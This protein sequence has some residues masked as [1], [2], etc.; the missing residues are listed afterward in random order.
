MKRETFADVACRLF[1]EVEG[2]KQTKMPDLGLCLLL[3]NTRQKWNLINCVYF[4]IFV[5]FGSATQKLCHIC[6]L[7]RLR[8]QLFE[9]F[10]AA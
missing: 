10:L 2:Q 1:V 8:F 9:I 5:Y 7:F 3:H 4:D 6:R